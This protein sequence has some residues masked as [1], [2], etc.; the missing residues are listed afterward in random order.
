[1]QLKPLIIWEKWQDPIL[2]N[3][4]DITDHISD[5]NTNEYNEDYTTE[6][7]E[8]SFDQS[9]SYKY[10]LII[11][12]MGLLPYN[13]KTSCDKVFNFWVGH[14]NFSITKDISNILE[15]SIGVE[16]LDIFTRY[17]FRIG[18]GKAFKDS[19]IM[20]NINNKIYEHINEY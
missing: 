8:E 17:R 12:P 19:K 7:N 10:P 15:E 16:T 1:M 20:T 6:E 13:E 5:T 4:T 3:L 2:N 9:K 14:T 11:T 18:I